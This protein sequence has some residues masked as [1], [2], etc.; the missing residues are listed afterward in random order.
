MAAA[1]LLVE[2]RAQVVLKDRRARFRV[3]D[4]AK[5][6]ALDDATVLDWRRKGWL[7]LVY[8]HLISISNW[9]NLVD[10]VPPADAADNQKS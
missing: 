8:C 1:G 3:I 2:N 9:S 6:N 5:L 10:R 7:P 4:E